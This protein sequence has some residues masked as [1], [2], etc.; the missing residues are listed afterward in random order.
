[1]ADFS[2]GNIVDS[3]GGGIGAALRDTAGMTS[4]SNAM[5]RRSAMAAAETGEDI[6]DEHILRERARYKDEQDWQDSQYKDALEKQKEQKKK[7]E[8]MLGEE[9]HLKLGLASLEEQYGNFSV[10][11]PQEIGD[12]IG[13]D[14]ETKKRRD[15][16][17]QRQQMQDNLLRQKIIAQGKASLGTD[18]QV[19]NRR[20]NI[21]GGLG[22][23]Q[24][25]SSGFMS[26]SERQER[27]ARN[28][29]REGIGAKG[30]SLTGDGGGGRGKKDK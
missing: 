26:D 23:T 17:I 21:A 24:G 6:S 15:Q 3:I 18:M 25:S 30:V 7:Y 9:E 14:K 11:P 27:N 22:Q 8:E 20:V 28:N 19:Q 5:K 16:M 4:Q 29:K 13:F 2:W 1:M 10:K 12:L